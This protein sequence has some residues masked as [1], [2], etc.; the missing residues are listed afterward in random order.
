MN[1]KFHALIPALATALILWKAST[2]EHGL[3]ALF[4][5]TLVSAALAAGLVLFQSP[6]APLAVPVRVK[7]SPSR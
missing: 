5:L 2:V 4:V 3:E 6:P 1:L 7:T